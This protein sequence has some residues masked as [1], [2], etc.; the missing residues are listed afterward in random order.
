MAQGEYEIKIDLRA[1]R[2]TVWR[3]ITDFKSYR[4]WNS[5]LE[6]ADNDQLE[7]GKKFRVAIIE[8]NGK[9]SKFS[10][11]TISKEE[12]RSFS[13]RQVILANWFFSATHY[14]ILEEA[15]EGTV[16]FIQRWRLTGIL[17]TLFKKQIFRQLALFNRMNFELKKYLEKSPVPV[18]R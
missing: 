8:E 12:L 16:R 2:Q 15:G 5:M 18:N 7:V 1:D 14:F 11:E 4:H 13:A 3:T 9:K 10:A 6:M 17:S